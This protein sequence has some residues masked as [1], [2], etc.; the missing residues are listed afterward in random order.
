MTGALKTAPIQKLGRKDSNLRM[1][2][3]KSGALPLGDSPVIARW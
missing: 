2:D 3:P 1:P